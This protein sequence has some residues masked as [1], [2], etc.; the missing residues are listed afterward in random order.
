MAVESFA[1]VEAKVDA[2][3]TVGE[4]DWTENGLSLQDES[5]ILL[6]NSARVVH[7][8]QLYFAPFFKSTFLIKILILQFIKTQDLPGLQIVTE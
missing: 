5:Q 6:S 7:Q 1:A 2:V 3:A 4:T 8:D